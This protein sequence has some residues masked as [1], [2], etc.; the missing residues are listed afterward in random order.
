MFF[1]CK[2]GRN[3]NYGNLCVNCRNRHYGDLILEDDEDMVVEKDDDNYEE[4]KNII[5]EVEDEE[6]N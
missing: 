4:L 3:T 5:E 1:R 2:C 6:Q